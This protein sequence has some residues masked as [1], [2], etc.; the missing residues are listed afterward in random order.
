M[1]VL[2]LTTEF[3][4]VIYGGLGTAVGGWV[5]ASSRAGLEVGVLL[6]E[7]DLVLDS[8]RYGAARSAAWR[9]EG[10]LVDPEGIGFV[11]CRWSEAIG[12]GLRLIDRFRPDVLHLHTSMLWYLGRELHERTATPLV[13]H[14][15]SVDRAEYE[16]G[17]EPSPWLV[18]T[19]QEEAIRGS[20]RL[21]AISDSER[22]LLDL[23]YPESSRRVRVVGNGIDDTT[24]ARHAAV[25]RSSAGSAVVLY[26]GRLVERKGIREL[27]EAIPRVL[28]EAPDTRFV[29]VGG[30]PG[31]PG[32]VLARQW[33]PGSSEEIESLCRNVT[34]TG[35]LT[36]DQ[37]A[38]WYAVADV[39]VIPSRYE[40]FGMVVLEGM[41]YGLALVATAVGGPAE[42]LEPGRTALLVPARDAA[43]LGDAI[44]R[45]VQDADLRHRL[46]RAAREDIEA[47]WTWDR[48]VAEMKKVYSELAAESFLFPWEEERIAA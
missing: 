6:V 30:P 48:R 3:P 1:R 11:R 20:D 42:I 13:Y 28:A 15:H 33:L 26:S 27:T 21:I 45:L 4:P 9:A 18:H 29:I 24:L 32:E 35:W 7:G 47:R 36:P 31:V 8:P 19:E 22:E 44:L 43:A 46:G 39:Q 17:A 5:K 12:L 25:R 37:V 38:G 41:L 34:F 14:V 23:Y 40:P 16:V 2:H 10:G